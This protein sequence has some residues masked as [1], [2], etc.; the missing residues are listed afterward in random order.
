MSCLGKGTDPNVQ[1]ASH[2]TTLMWAVRGDSVDIVELLIEHHADVNL[3]GSAGETPLHIATDST[4]NGST[5]NGTSTASDIPVITTVSSLN[6]TPYL[7]TTPTSSSRE[8]ICALLL[9]NGA[10]PNRIC[11]KSWSPLLRAC[12]RGHGAL[13]ESLLSAAASIYVGDE[14]GRGALHWAITGLN[15]PQPSDNTSRVYPTYSSSPPPTNSSSSSSPSSSSSFTSPLD[16]ARSK[17][18]SLIK[19][20]LRY[21]EQTH[22][23]AQRHR[24]GGNIPGGSGST[25]SIGVERGGDGSYASPRME[26]GGGSSNEMS[27]TIHANGHR[28]SDW[29][30]EMYLCSTSGSNSTLTTGNR[31]QSPQPIYS[32]STCP[33]S[34]RGTLYIVFKEV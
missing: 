24:K 29:N 31:S 6:N 30:S 10:Q 15:P 13:A 9:A 3:A 4:A 32:L 27:T 8:R 33:L 34:L 16:A 21:I 23:L 5:N 17:S 26:G 2:N 22:G 28:Y 20:L 18:H 1:D 12:A 7:T 11:T 19:I 14:R 25:S